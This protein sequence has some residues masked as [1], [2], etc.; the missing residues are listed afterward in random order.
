MRMKLVCTCAALWA[1]VG[2]IRASFQNATQV[3]HLVMGVVK[4]EVCQTV[5]LMMHLATCH[6]MF[7]HDNVL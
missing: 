5:A 1:S 2:C 4:P 3:Q 6:F 7:S